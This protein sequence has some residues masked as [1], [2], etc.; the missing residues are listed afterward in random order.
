MDRS[1]NKEIRRVL[2]TYTSGK[3][4]REVEI[5]GVENGRAFV[6]PTTFDPLNDDA[7]YY[8][9]W[10]TDVTNLSAIH[11]LRVDGTREYMGNPPVNSAAQ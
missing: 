3:E 6:Q 10:M 7:I 1:G 2:A 11:L 5:Q 4:K 8:H 9:G